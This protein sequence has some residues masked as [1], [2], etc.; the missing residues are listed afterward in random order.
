M[1]N[2]PIPHN[3]FS[4]INLGFKPKLESAKGPIIQHACAIV[5]QNVEL[6]YSNSEVKA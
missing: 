1:H 5:L 4:D 6:K 2:L 3:I